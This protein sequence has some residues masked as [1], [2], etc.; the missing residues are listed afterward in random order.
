MQRLLRASKRFPLVNIWK[1][2]ERKLESEVKERGVNLG[3]EGSEELSWQ[4]ELL[5]TKTLWKEE[6]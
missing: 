6:Q 2:S 5:F 3:E 4:K 1:A